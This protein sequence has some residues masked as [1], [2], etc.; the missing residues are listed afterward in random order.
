MLS[1]RAPPLDMEAWLTPKTRLLPHTRYR[2]KF[3]AVWSSHFRV[4]KGSL[5]NWGRRALPV[6][7]E[8]VID[9][10]EIGPVPLFHNT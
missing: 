1:L 9:Q 5:K 3:V 4:G 2:T 10:L 6:W 7:G 8:G